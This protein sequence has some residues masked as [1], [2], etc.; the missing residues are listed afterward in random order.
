MSL[1]ILGLGTAL[2]HSVVSRD[3]GERIARS[4]VHLTPEQVGWLPHVYA[5]AGIDQRHFCLDRAI[6]RD[7]LDGTNHTQSPFLPDGEENSRGPTTGE[8]MAVYREHAPR[9]AHRASH[10]AL[11]HSGVRANEISHLV[12]VSCTGFHAPDHDLFVDIIVNPWNG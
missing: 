9:L 10:A 3:E 12:T 4:V 11:E 5:G 1:A 8:R 6:V 7:A 2:P